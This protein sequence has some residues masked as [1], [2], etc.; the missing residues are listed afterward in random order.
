MVVLPNSEDDSSEM[1]SHLIN[2]SDLLEDFITSTVPQSINSL[3]VGIGSVIMM[4]II[5]TKISLE[6]MLVCLVLIFIIVPISKYLSIVSENIQD[7][8]AKLLNITAQLRNQ[9]RTIR[10]YNAKDYA[11][12]K[13]KENN[14]ILKK[15]NISRIRIFSIYSPLINILMLFTSVLVVWL[16]NIEVRNG[17]LTTGSAVTFVVYLS[18]LIPTI[19]QITQFITYMGYL[20]GG[21]QHIINYS[22]VSTEKRGGINISKIKEISFDNVS[23]S[24]DKKKS[25]LD[26]ISLRIK[27]GDYITIIGESGVGKSTILDILECNLQPTKGCLKINSIP[28]KK[29]DRY[30]LRECIS[31]ISQEKDSLAGTVRELITFNS[32]KYTDKQIW[33]SLKIAKLDNIFKD[34]K[35]GLSTYIEEAGRNFSGGQMQRLALARGLLKNSDVILLDE[36][37]A[38]VDEKTNLEI[39]KN[40]KDNLRINDKIII[41]VI[42]NVNRI[43]PGSIV[44]Q[45]KDKKLTR[46]N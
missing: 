44:Y 17:R 38:N 3:V 26:D 2:D 5:S 16:G 34:S 32:G 30:S 31:Y 41:E 8:K 39:R 14:R 21:L 19:M 23:F 18:Q 4:F 22:K 24:Y 13:F 35:D 42:H 12:D 15:S 1:A 9:A 28:V 20:N 6:V 37:F 45:L 36:A 7:S 27:L 10:S 11:I 40:I 33:N 43:Q 25:I 29:I 46:L